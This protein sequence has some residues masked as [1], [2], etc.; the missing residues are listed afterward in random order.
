MFEADDRFGELAEQALGVAEQRPEVDVGV[1]AELDALA[2]RRLR[3]CAAARGGRAPRR[4]PRGSVRARVRARPRAA[5]ARRPRRSARCPSGPGRGCAT[6][7]SSAGRRRRSGGACTSACA[8]ALRRAAARSRSC[9]R[10]R[11]SARR[12]R[13]RA[14]AAASKSSI[15]LVGV[16]ALGEDRAEDLR[17]AGFGGVATRAP[18]GR[19][20]RSRR[21]RL[22]DA[23]RPR[24]SAARRARR[25]ASGPVLILH[26]RARPRS[27]VGIAGSRSAAEPGRRRQAGRRGPEVERLSGD[28]DDPA[29][30]AGF[31][32]RRRPA[33][34]RSAASDAVDL[35]GRRRAS[36]LRVRREQV[37]GARARARRAS[38]RP[39]TA[40]AASGTARCGVGAAVV[41]RGLYGPARSA[42]ISSSA[43]APVPLTV[44]PGS[45][46]PAAAH[47][48][49][50]SRHASRSGTSRSRHASS[51]ADVLVDVRDDEL[52]L[53]VAVERGEARAAGPLLHV[54]RDAAARRRSPAR[55]SSAVCAPYTSCVGDRGDRALEVEEHAVV[56]RDDQSGPATS[57]SPSR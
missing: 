19:G 28:V 12:G 4:A 2:Q 6:R 44:G 33:R 53:H 16:V 37:L 14:A 55:A 45:R 18:G 47:E 3:R 51:G 27:P 21:G 42:S 20:V 30:A 8:V 49:A 7:A 5:A 36:R 26:P 32:G 43:A 29:G 48:P 10:S 54:E 31:A 13:R 40:S 23:R 15:A 56:Q 41:E 38:A 35:V 46:R 1:P 22:A 24:G 11:R 25:P 9:C 34:A 52:V 17:G 57:L 39:G 50:A